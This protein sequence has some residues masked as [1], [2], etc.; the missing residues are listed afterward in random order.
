MSWE[1][2][3]ILLCGVIFLLRWRKAGLEVHAFM[4]GSAKSPR[5]AQLMFLGTG[6]LL[7]LAGVLALLGVIRFGN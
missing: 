3:G 2:V 1:A 4:G 7:S 6:V 5:A